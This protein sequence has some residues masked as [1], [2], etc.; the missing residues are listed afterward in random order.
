M[1]LMIRARWV[2]ECRLPAS[3]CEFRMELES[4]ERKKDQI[5]SIGRQMVAT[6][7]FQRKDGVFMVARPTDEGPNPLPVMRWSGPSTWEQQRWI[8]D[9][10]RPETV[11]YYVATV[12]WRPDRRAADGA[13]NGADV[14]PQRPVAGIL[15]VPPTPPLVANPARLPVRGMLGSLCSAPRITA[16]DAR[17]RACVLGRAGRAPA[18]RRR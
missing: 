16:R 7:Q 17:A 6:W 15:N 9:E 3:V 11:D 1:N 13:K 18:Y 14:P 8:R 5:A 12:V 10:S 2:N 4:L